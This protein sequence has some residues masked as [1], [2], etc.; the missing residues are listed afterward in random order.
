MIVS[1]V[2]LGIRQSGRQPGQAPWQLPRVQ[3]D[4]A[5]WCLARLREMCRSTGA[6]AGPG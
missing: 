4:R 2:G 6:P 1:Q 5:R 3:A